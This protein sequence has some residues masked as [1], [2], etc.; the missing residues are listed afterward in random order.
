MIK[1]SPSCFIGLAILLCLPFNPARSAELTEG[2][3]KPFAEMQENFS[4]EKQKLFLVMNFINEDQTKKSAGVIYS[5]EAKDRGYLVFGERPLGEKGQKACIKYV[6]SNLHFYSVDSKKPD[7]SNGQ[8]TIFTALSGT[9]DVK[10]IFNPEK[11]NGAWINENIKK[12]VT[13]LEDIQYTDLA[14][15]VADHFPVSEQEMAFA[16]AWDESLAKTG[17]TTNAQ[18][19]KMLWQ[20]ARNSQ[21]ATDWAIESGRASK[22]DKEEFKHVLET[23]PYVQEKMRQGVQ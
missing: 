15:G 6:L 7:L 16:K 8:M 9:E 18:H 21:K 23:Y 14:T 13:F 11:A 1:P 19:L 5:N 12:S 17:E 22:A 4:Q 20:N 3:C 2:T 10:I